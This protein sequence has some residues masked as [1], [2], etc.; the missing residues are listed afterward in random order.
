MCC[1]NI[2]TVLK[3]KLLNLAGNNTRSASLISEG[4]IKI[5]HRNQKFSAQQDCSSLIFGLKKIGNFT[6]K[7]S[8]NF[9]NF[10]AGNF[11]QDEIFER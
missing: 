9:Q 5:K 2:L 3:R 10:L 4:K 8:G 1:Q 7:L 11:L 6:S